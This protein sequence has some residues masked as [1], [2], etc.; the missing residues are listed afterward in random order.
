MNY[1]HIYHAGN[2][3]DV[4][5]HIV[6]M[7]VLEY[8]GEKD[9]PFFALDTHAGIGLYD[10]YDEA[11]QKTAE[12]DEGIRRLWASSR[13]PEII[14]RYLGLIRRFNRRSNGALRHYP[15]SPLIVREMLRPGDRMTANELHPEDH[16]RLSAALGADR[17]VRV[18]KED[19]YVLLKSQLPPPERRGL[20]LV[21][22]P[23]EARD[24]FARMVRGL[25]EAHRRWAQGVY[26][27]WYPVKDRALVDAY[28]RD[29]GETGIPRILAADFML[30]RPDSPDILNGC[31]LAIVNPPWTLK[32]QIRDVAPWLAQTLT[33]G[34][35][36]VRTAVLRGEAGD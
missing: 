2:F 17:R 29:L 26:M 14:T 12:S 34:E 9:K 36:Y 20:V 23:F 5:K 21:D 32:A 4:F 8:L 33:G 3:A 10:L 16:P 28:H 30:R 6:L 18:T 31:G 25:R 27:F 22:P 7:L 1:R 15:G 24:E 11:A 19:G 35:G 13:H